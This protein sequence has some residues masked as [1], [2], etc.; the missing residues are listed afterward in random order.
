MGKKETALKHFSKYIRIR[1]A[2][3]TTGTI[4]HARCITCGKLLPIVEM[5]AGHAIPGRKNAILFLEEICHAQCNTCNR[6]LKGRLK[7]FKH[8][9]I[10]LH[11]QDKWD[12]WEALKRARVKYIDSDYEQIGI[13]YREKVKEL[14][15]GFI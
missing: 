5:D 9:L 10:N 8:I 12:D 15:R 1:D 11:G 4:T 6:H 13:K 3:K 14:V 2:I 7:D